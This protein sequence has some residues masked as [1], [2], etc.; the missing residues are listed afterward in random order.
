M[1]FTA[2]FTEVERSVLTIEL[3]KTYFLP[4]RE[5]GVHDDFAADLPT[6]AV[7]DDLGLATGVFGTGIPHLISRD[8]NALGATTGYARTLFSMPAEYVT[9][10]AIQLRLVSGM[11][12]A[13]A[14][15]SALAD[16]EIFVSAK[17]TLKQGSDLVSTAA[18]SMNSTVFSSAIFDVSSSTLVPGSL[19]DIRVA[20]ICNS[21][22]A[23]AHF[24]AIAHAELLLNIRG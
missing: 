10:S 9:G 3:L 12:T 20:L 18:I 4:F 17:N 16:A 19:L 2:T 8:L 24:A 22:T 15:V 1:A 13:A 7:A 11:L 14:S 23:S 5:F 6:V 21:A